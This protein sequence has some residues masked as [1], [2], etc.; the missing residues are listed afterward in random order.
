MLENHGECDV[1]IGET[2]SRLT[3]T[4]HGAWTLYRA[5]TQEARQKGAATWQHRD[6]R[7]NKLVSWKL[8]NVDQK[9]HERRCVLFMFIYFV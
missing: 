7:L 6:V 2:K 4:K 3:G 1:N 9:E 8:G 5:A